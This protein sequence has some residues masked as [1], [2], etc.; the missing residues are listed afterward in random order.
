MRLRPERAQKSWS[1]RTGP[2]PPGLL[3]ANKPLR[4]DI[5]NLLAPTGM[6][7]KVNLTDNALKVVRT[8]DEDVEEQL[9]YRIVSDTLK[10]YLFLYT[11]PATH[12]PPCCWT[13]P[14]RTPS[15]LRSTPGR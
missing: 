9:P 4:T 1:R 5:N 12:R 2:T 7:L 14:S 8:V 13:S 10:R 3:A 11:I 6:R 15:V